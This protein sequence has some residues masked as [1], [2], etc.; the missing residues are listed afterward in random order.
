MLGNNALKKYVSPCLNMAKSFLHYYKWRTT[1][2]KN[3]ADFI[4]DPNKLI[5]EV[6]V[7]YASNPTETFKF[8]KVYIL[9]QQSYLLL[10]SLHQEASESAIADIVTSG[11]GEVLEANMK[12]LDHFY[13]QTE[14]SLYEYNKV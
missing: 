14:Y 10:T 9:G 2:Q 1:S 8:S 13:G 11:N 6:T 12:I 3:F 4:I 7:K 5:A